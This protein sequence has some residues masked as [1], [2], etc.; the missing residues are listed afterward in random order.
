VGES[1]KDWSVGS[2]LSIETLTALIED[3]SVDTVLTVFPDMYGRL[4]GKRNTGHF[5]LSDVLQGG[6]HACDYLFACDM[7]MDP[8]PGYEWSSWEKGYGDVHA[9]V[10]LSS[11]RLAAWQDRTALVLCDLTSPVDHQPVEI[12]PRR[13]LSRQVGL[14]RELGYDPRAGS[15]LEFFVLSESYDEAEARDFGEP[16]TSGWYVEDYHTMHA[17]REEPIIGA[18]R[19]A[20][21]ASGV[22]VESS[23]GEWGPGQHEINLRYTD[24]LEMAD[25]H[26]IFKQAAKEIAALQDGSVTF[27]AKLHENLAGNSMHL[28][29]SL[30]SVDGGEALF[31]GDNELP[32]TPARCSDLFRWYIGGLVAHA[33]E[34]ALWYAPNTNSYRRFIAGTF[35]PTGIRWSWDN[36]TAGYRLVGSGD[37]L[38]V[39]CRIPG[40]D[41]NPYLVMAVTLAA[42]LDGIRNRIEPPAA[43]SG[44][45]YQSADHATLPLCL[46]D[47]MKEFAD[48]SFILSAFG[49]EVRDHYLRFAEVEL[50]KSRPVVPNWERR[51]FLERG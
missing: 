8:V 30:W 4:V 45:L 5:F 6:L 11:L 24:M 21:D 38:R 2:G 35:A 22:P 16:R 13:I 40:G 14:A 3:G 9:T 39:E 19:R 28:H 34:C 36:R 31:S 12:S 46:E 33:R 48:S 51:R 25:R 27:M 32:G 50:E 15:E 49:A 43:L 17:T 10:D 44:D 18:I 1:E 41:A 47:A 7:E 23:K 26:S 20:M 29:S 42:G 37:A